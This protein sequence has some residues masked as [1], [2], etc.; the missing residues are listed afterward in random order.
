MA[1]S[2]PP[3]APSELCGASTT[4]DGRDVFCD[5]PIGHPGDKHQGKLVVEWFQRMP[6]DA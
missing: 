1:E 3:P 6:T 4:Q 5:L 2:M